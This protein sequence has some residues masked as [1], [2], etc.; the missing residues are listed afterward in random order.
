MIGSSPM[1]KPPI[2]IDRSISHAMVS[3]IWSLSR[4]DLRTHVGPVDN[5][6]VRS[7]PLCCRFSHLALF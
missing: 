2:G 6:D 4:I 3:M 1:R 7:A 5:L